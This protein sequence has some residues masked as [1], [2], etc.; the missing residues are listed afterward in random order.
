MK[1]YLLDTFAFNLATNLQLLDKIALLPAPEEAIRHMSHLVNCQYK[2]MARLRQDPK[3]AEMSW[4]EPTYPLER[5]A[6]EWQASTA[7]W[8]DYIASLSEEELKAEASY[9]G[10]D[11]GTWASKPLDIALQLCYHA[12]HH[13][14]QI[15]LFLRQQ[16]IDPDFV[17]YIGTKQKKIS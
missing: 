17:D 11:G 9:T 1:T 5:L 12:I 7:L 6:H 14:A 15:Q 13:R 10:Y 16:D 4:W 2:W 8:T 3:A